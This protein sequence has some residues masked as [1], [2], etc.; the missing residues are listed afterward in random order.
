MWPPVCASLCMH[1]VTIFLP[2]CCSKVLPLINMCASTAE[3]CIT[4]QQMASS[5]MRDS[6]KHDSFAHIVN[7][8][9]HKKEKRNPLAR[10]KWNGLISKIPELSESCE[11]VFANLL[12]GYIMESRSNRVSYTLKTILYTIYFLDTSIEVACLTHILFLCSFQMHLLVKYN[13]STVLF[14]NCKNTVL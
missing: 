12:L 10:L 6:T 4:W 13:R 11:I 8:L 5:T 2:L 14:Q 1:Y 9:C 7:L 3:R